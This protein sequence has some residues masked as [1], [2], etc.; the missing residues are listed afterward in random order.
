MGEFLA[1][2]TEGFADMESIFQNLLRVSPITNTKT[3][4]PV[5]PATPVQTSQQV[6][7]LREMLKDKKESADSLLDTA[8]RI[9]PASKAIVA[10]ESAYDASFESEVAAPLPNSSATLQGFTLIFFIISFFSLAIV[11]S[12]YAN[13]LSGNTNDALVTFGIFLLIFIVCFALVRRFG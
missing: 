6:A 4:M 3:M 5:N 9:S 2:V 10:L 13:N 12:V 11:A 8:K 7:F 1:P